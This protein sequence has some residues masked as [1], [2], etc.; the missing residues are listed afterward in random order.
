MALPVAGVAAVLV[1]RGVT[2]K[3]RRRRRW[4]A[5]G[6]FVLV[7]GVVALL[8]VALLAGWSGD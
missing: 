8:V 6:W 2:P 7:A 4:L 1:E 3:N 5:V